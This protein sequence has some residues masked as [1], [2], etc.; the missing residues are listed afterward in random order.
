[1]RKAVGN[2]GTV[3]TIVQFTVDRES[4]AGNTENTADKTVWSCSENQ[5]K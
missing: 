1:V 3:N 2:S 4:L 5:N